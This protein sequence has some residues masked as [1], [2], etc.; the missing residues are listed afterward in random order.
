MNV[1]VVGAG[2]REHALVWRLKSSKSVKKLACAPGNPGMEREAKRHD[3]APDDVEGLVQ[4]ARREKSDLVVVGPEAPLVAGLA[5]RLRSE[6]I[7][8]LGPSRSAAEL[9][10]SKVFA[11]QFMRRHRIP[12]APF[13]VFDSPERAIAGIK[14]RGAPVVVKA[15][16]LAAGKGVR[17]AGTLEEAMT[18]VRDFMIRKIHGEA[19]RKVVVEEVLKGREVS[20]MALSDGTEVLPLLPAMDHKRAFDGDRGPN[21]GGMGAVA[22]SPLLGDPGAAEAVRQ[23]LLP[24]VR[25][26]AEEGRPFV[27]I[28]YAG[29]M[30]SKGRPQ[31]LEFN[32]RLGDPEAQVVL[33]LIE[34]DFAELLLKAA[35]G[36]LKGAK[37]SLRPGAA[38]C[39]VLASGGYPDD[40]EKGKAIEG[41]EEAEKTPETVVFHA[42][43]ARDPAGKWTT[44]G[45][46][47]LGVTARGGSLEE[48]VERSYAAAGKI[49]WEGMHYRKDIGREAIRL[50]PP[51]PHAP[52]G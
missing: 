8:V 12:T 10:G 2:G 49:R 5:D 9:E 46:R 43:T 41:I 19:G 36:K 51:S 14:R 30:V 29:L 6:G 1:L 25:G 45:G 31:V 42:G 22:P 39:V 33:P 24:A 20:L 26:M 16:G 15:D 48:A 3:V 32:V 17:V 4:L 34:G 18:A 50:L 40:Y 13:E 7:P 38:A 35:E 52:G 28:L 44:A 23:V 37:V 47:V 11:K 27:G 21:T